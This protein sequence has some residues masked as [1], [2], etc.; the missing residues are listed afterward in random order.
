MDVSYAIER[1]NANEE[2]KKLSGYFLCSCFACIKQSKEE[3]KQWTLLYYNPDS[4]KVLDCFV[5]D[6]F[7]TLGDETPP[8]AEIEKPD[9]E[10][11]KVTV[12]DALEKAAKDYRKSTLNVLITLH[13]KQR[14]V[15]TIN[16]ISGDMMATTVDVDAKTGEIT[17]REETSLIRR[18]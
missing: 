9:F 6:K 1:A 15:W 17:R 12:E 5:N 18:L 11:L 14:L 7:V 8:L 2:I 10:E 3:I 13:Q 4:R 16:L